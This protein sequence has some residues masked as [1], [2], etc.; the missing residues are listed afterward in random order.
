MRFSV[1]WFQ[2]KLFSLK[3]ATV[4]SLSVTPFPPF[5]FSFCI[6]SFI[7][8]LE[9]YQEH[10]VAGVRLGDEKFNILICAETEWNKTFQD[11][12]QK[13]LSL[14]V[15]SRSFHI[16]FCSI[17]YFIVSRERQECCFQPN[18]N[19]ERKIDEILFMTTLSW[20]VWWHVKW[21]IFSSHVLV[22]RG[23]ETK[24]WCTM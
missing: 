6:C 24:T 19:F 5:N 14:E 23:T 22:H 21:T 8:Q 15:F 10:L 13:M 11:V 17:F 9:K 16:F 1:F 20:G 12:W 2:A 4:G 3:N 7:H 18:H